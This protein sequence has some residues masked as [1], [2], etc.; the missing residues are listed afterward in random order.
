M[1]VQ[2]A[3]PGP[4]GGSGGGSDATQ[5][6]EH[7]R[8]FRL[9]AASRVAA[10]GAR[11]KACQKGLGHQ[12][13]CDRIRRQGNKV[14]P[15]RHWAKRESR[16][17]N[18]LA[19]AA[20]HFE[21]ARGHARR[22]SFEACQADVELSLAYRLFP[23]EDLALEGQWQAGLTGDRLTFRPVQAELAEVLTLSAECLLELSQESA[24]AAQLLRAHIALVA[25]S[26][27]RR[28][29][30]VVDT[31]YLQTLQEQVSI[32]LNDVLEQTP[33]ESL[34]PLA[35]DVGLEHSPA[36]WNS[37]VGL[38][39]GI[40]KIVADGHIFRHMTLETGKLAQGLYS[41]GGA[42]EPA[43]GGW[44][45]SAPHLRSGKSWSGSLETR[46]WTMG[47]I[48]HSPSYRGGLSPRRWGL[49]PPPP[50]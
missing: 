22:Q 46:P 8:A 23:F 16:G 36:L 1:L 12:E 26:V 18:R 27:L 4:E 49:C 34:R 14:G 21:A 10:L 31:G 9:A 33:L 38:V 19:K 6:A 3:A 42:Q 30:G 2:A 15:L 44:E 5:C 35:R 25:A 41:A 20:E 37:P 28:Q 29:A 47:R 13:E 17:W 11:Q 32:D 48:S 39:K 24:D 50:S 40:K 7:G 43:Q 45:G